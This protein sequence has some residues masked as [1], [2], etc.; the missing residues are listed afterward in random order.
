M[1]ATMAL[2][3]APVSVA[4]ANAYAPGVVV[5]RNTALT[6]ASPHVVISGSVVSARGATVADAVVMALTAGRPP[7]CSACSSAAR[8]PGPLGTTPASFSAA[9][10]LG[11]PKPTTTASTVPG[12]APV[13]VTC[14]VGDGT[15]STA[16]AAAANARCSTG[17]KL[18]IV[19]F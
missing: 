18:A 14:T 12:A 17:P 1:Q 4:D 9:V 2:F 11:A 5:T 10:A 13:Y 7:A 19:M 6:V 8:A 15:P 16:A 3:C